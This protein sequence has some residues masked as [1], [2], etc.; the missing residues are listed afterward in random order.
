M[1]IFSVEFG[2][3]FSIFWLIYFALNFNQTLQKILILS[4][5]YIF[6][7]LSNIDYLFINVIFSITIYLLSIFIFHLNSKTIF[8][9][10]VS[11]VVGFLAFFKNI[12]FLDFYLENFGLNFFENNLLPLGLSFYSF[13]SICYLHAVF[14]RQIKPKFID[15][16]VFLSFFAVIVSGP[17]LNPKRFLRSLNK[18]KIFCKSNEI[19]TLLCLAI[20]KKLIVANYLFE[21]V[22]PIFNA[23][24]EP[25]YILLAACFGYTAMIYADFSG[26]ID[27][28]LALGLMCG[29]KLPRNFNRPFLAENLIE[30]WRRWH[31][32]LMAFFK[33][34]I[35]IPL[36]GSKKGRLRNYFAIMVV[37]LVSGFWHGSGLG[38]ITWGF[39]H[40]VGVI[41]LRLS[42][43]LQINCHIV[44]KRYATIVFVS[45][46]WV[47]FVLDFD[48]AI[49]Y[50]K[51]ILSGFE[52]EYLQI[53]SV[54]LTAFFVLTIYNF[55]D[56]YAII[57]LLFRASNA[58]LSAI[59]LIF[60]ALIIY[61]LMPESMPN[62]IY[63]GF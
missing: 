7:Y 45:I 60:F 1:S 57:R 55:F 15:T 54:L 14:K 36:G 25:A 49:D 16:L 23:Q 35:Y 17:I 41:F 44:F 13:M 39:C 50:F 62:F 26:Y 22:I 37:F 4:F 63:Q 51:L 52:R 10:S 8:I 33:N 30:F 18:K 28:V 6:L 61:I 53:L 12:G 27:F 21:L 3:F 9:S 29:F 11:F 47:F 48:L 46:I 38:F 40:G 32:T 19:Y 58:F 43:N 20:F 59:F 24:S 5:S 34:F 2:V 31:I 42:Q 56:F